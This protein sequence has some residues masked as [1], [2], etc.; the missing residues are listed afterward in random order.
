MRFHQG[1]L[2]FLACFALVL[3]LTAV[4]FTR[5]SSVQLVNLT[6]AE[7][8]EVV[9]EF[10]RSGC[11]GNC[12]DYKI[13]VHGDGRTE[14]E[15]RKDV[16]QIGHKNGHLNPGDVKSLVAEFDK[17]NFLTV[18]QFTEKSCSCT[19]CTDMPTATTEIRAKGA[20]HRVEHYFGCR[21]APKAL[22][23]LEAAID[24]IAHTEQWTGDVSKQG[25]LATTCFGR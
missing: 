18:D 21:C 9:I 25:P 24:K 6:E 8:K 20:S 10:E 17:A 12:P 5:Q 15:G 13:T 1:S 14:Y 19:L 4:G 7:L 22:W 11:Y 16:K 23:D 3:A 2:A